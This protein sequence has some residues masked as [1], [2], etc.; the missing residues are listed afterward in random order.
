[1]ESKKETQMWSYHGSQVV[2]LPPFHTTH[3]LNSLNSLSLKIFSLTN[4]LLYFIIISFLYSFNVYF[5]WKLSF[6]A[7]Y[8]FPSLVHSLKRRIFTYYT[9]GLNVCLYV[10]VTIRSLYVIINGRTCERKKETMIIA[11]FMV[12]FCL[13]LNFISNYPPFFQ[14]SHIVECGL[15]Q[16]SQPICFFSLTI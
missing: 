9:G 16:S 8:S 1:M 3:S 13:I 2:M 12:V 11:I 7:P 14:F 5:P 10:N 15:Q 4:T 6:Y